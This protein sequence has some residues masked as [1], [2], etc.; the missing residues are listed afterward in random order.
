MIYLAVLFIGACFSILNGKSKGFFHSYLF[1]LLML[2]CFRYGVGPDYFSYEFLYTVVNTSVVDQFNASGQE[3]LFRLL[4]SAL[5]SFDFTYQEY[6]AFTALITL[7]YI[8]KTCLRYS[9]YPVVSLFFYYCFFY[10]V[11]VFSGIRQGLTLAIGVYYLLECL[12][13]RNHIKFTIITFILTLIHASS[14][15]LPLFYVIAHLNLR[16]KTL[17]VGVFFCFCISFIPANY[18]MEIFNRLPYGDRIDFYFRL[19]NPEDFSISYFDFKS[20]ARFVLLILFGV[21]FAKNYD[22]SNGI[23][24]KIMNIYVVSFGFYYALRF[25]EILASNA[26]I[27]GFVLL[28]VILPNMYGRLKNGPN[29]IV[30]L[31]FVS[32]LSIAF[33]FKTLF[34]MEDMSKV[35]HSSLIIPYTNIF[36]KYEYSFPRRVI[37]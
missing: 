9:H 21:L 14:A 12:E 6:V 30:F 11:W 35:S 5:Q 7:Y 37:D 20:I 33:F 15:I 8:G 25:L 2:A 24:S 18:Y 13:N 28:V 34:S 16:R 22:N 29:S 17:L 10:F 26:S 3:L 4:G 27:Y 19:G 23:H 1:L 32:I 36:N 31:F